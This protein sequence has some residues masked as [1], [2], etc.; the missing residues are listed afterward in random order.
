[1]GIKTYLREKLIDLSGYWIYRKRALPIG[2]DF[3]H[4]LKKIFSSNEITIFDV[5]ANV[6]ITTLRFRKQ[7]ENSIIYSFEPVNKTFSVLQRKVQL[8]DKVYCFKLALGEKIETVEIKTFE[9][10]WSVLNSLKPEA[11]NN[12]NEQSEAV[13]VVT[14]DSF[15]FDHKINHI[16]LLK[17]DT[18][19]YELKVLQGFEKMIREERVKAIYCEVGFSE[20]NTRNTFINDIIDFA[21]KNNFKFYGIYEISNLNIHLN[22]NYGNVFLIRGDL[23]SD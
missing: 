5:G 1:M 17:I 7:F 2:V 3:F 14:G 6:G 13:T 21:G 11:Q 4:D 12:A 15:C 19:G 23:T 20:K 22:K 8:L 9:E 10:D 16:D 18:E